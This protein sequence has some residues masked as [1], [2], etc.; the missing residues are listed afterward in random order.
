[1]KRLLLFCAISFAA[2]FWIVHAAPYLQSG[3]VA[4]AR[5]QV[6][7]ERLKVKQRLL[8]VTEV[9]E[10]QKLD[11]LTKTFSTTDEALQA[12]AAAPPAKKDGQASLIAFKVHYFV[13]SS[14]LPF[15]AE[16]RLPE[17]PC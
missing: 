7:I 10:R 6:E 3:D 5:Q 2:G 1:M 17:F 12:H 11:I 14:G 15:F 9:K 16:P 13:A 4:A 8:V